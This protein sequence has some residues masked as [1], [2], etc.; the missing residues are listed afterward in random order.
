MGFILKRT[1]LAFLAAFMEE[2]TAFVVAHF[3]TEV[4]RAI[5]GGSELRPQ[6]SVSIERAI[7]CADTQ[8]SIFLSCI[9]DVNTDALI[10][11]TRFSLAHNDFLD[12]AVLAEVFRTTES[13]Q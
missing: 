4:G 12:V 7:N 9:R 13:L 11:S 5:L 6:N 1:A 2:A 8:C 10:Y 3:A